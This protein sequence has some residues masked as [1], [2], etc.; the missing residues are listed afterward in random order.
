MSTQ[1]PAALCQALLISAPASGQGKTSVTAA[2]VMFFR[3]QGQRVRVFKTGP[4]FID[5]SIL[6][7]ASGQPVYQLDLWMSGQAHCQ[8]LL[9]QAAKTADIILIEGV[10]GLYDG[11]PSSADL[12]RLFNIPILA[13]IDGQS[14][15]QTFAAVA[16]GLA[17]FQDT[18]HSEP[19]P[20]FG[21]L[22]NHISGESHYD[23][24]V[25]DAHASTPIMGWM[26]KNPNMTLPERH[27][28][29]VQAHECN[30][31][32]AKLATMQEAL[33]LNP[34]SM[35]ALPK[36]TFSPSFN[37]KTAQPLHPLLKNKRI[38]IAKDEAFSFLYPANLD[39]LKEMGADL[40]FFSPLNDTQLPDA[41]AFYFPGGYPELHL[42]KLADNHTLIQQIQQAHANQIPILA[43]CGGMMYLFEALTDS[44]G[45]TQRLVGLLKG[46]C[47]MQPRLTNLGMHHA[48]FSQ[49]ELRGHTFHY[50][51]LESK[52]AS[53]LQTHPARAKR[54]PEAIFNKNALTASF[55]HWYFY[56]NPQAAAAFFLPET[57]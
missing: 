15:A 19:L 5:P 6:E 21:V 46:A 44:Q 41:D 27:L 3:Q 56:S 23:W 45:Q 10:M 11:E 49:G 37:S 40:L 54:K 55:M 14:M 22:A 47:L 1:N 17:H 2:L 9:Y 36:I 53:R 39:F 34:K 29:L 7:Q 25:Q 18:T 38:A 30:E 12:A 52:E 35:N 26:Q 43:E 42:K 50:G 32:E 24:L 51:K 16:Y 33:H 31:L 8:N 20:F 48:E 13:V 4:D 28:G 57:T